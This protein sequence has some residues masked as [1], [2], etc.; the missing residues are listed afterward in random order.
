MAATG[1]ILVGFL[2]GHLIGNLLI[3]FGPNA[4]NSYAKHL[5]DLLPLLWIARITLLVSLCA[6]IGSAILISIENKRARPQD[7]RNLKTVRTTISAKTMMLSGCMI[8]AYVIYHLMHFTFK[9]THPQF[10]HLI[11]SEGRHDVYTMI[12][13]SFQ[14]GRISG[15]YLI[16]MTLLC[17]H[18]S[19]AISSVFQTLALQ[20]PSLQPK[21]KTGGAIFAG[22]IF[23]GFSSIPIACLL[24]ILKG[25]V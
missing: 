25:A 5:Q 14:D 6:H 11:D 9:T 1:L 3:F 10:A 21:I 24:G 12:V 2:C 23:I 17:M 19:H 13:T 4:I 16:A 22:I 15:V 8:L 20:P 18:L 7:Y